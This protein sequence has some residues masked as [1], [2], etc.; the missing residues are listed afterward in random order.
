MTA[1]VEVAPHVQIA[2]EEQLVKSRHRVR[3]YGE[4]L[5]PRHMVHRM[6]DL[7]RDELEIGEEFVDRTFLEPAAGDGNFLIAILQRKLAAI[8][9][10]YP[11]EEWHAASLFALASIYGI[12]LLEDNHGDAKAAMLATFVRFHEIHGV[13]CGLRTNL[14]RS[15]EFL[16][17]ANVIRGNTL[18]GRDWRG[19]EIEFSWWHRVEGAPGMV[20]REPF[21]F[22][23]LREGAIDFNVYRDYEPCRIDKVHELGGWRG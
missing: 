3:A 12:E 1:Q 9:K 18:T 21:S 7:V 2:I 16:I 15:A 19:D 14:R 13:P 20:R 23:S 8:E 11:P 4:V 6:L 22:S 17:A 5:T 10:R